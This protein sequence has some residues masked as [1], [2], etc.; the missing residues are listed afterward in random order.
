ME[1]IRPLMPFVALFVITTV[2]MLR[3]RNDICS[4]EPRMLFVLFGTIFSNIC[5]STTSSSCNYRMIINF[6]RFQ[7][8]LIV[9]QMSDTRTECW[10]FF[11][12][13]LLLVVF[14][15]ILPSP[16]FLYIS[17][18]GERWL[19]Y[20]LT[21]SATIAH[22]HYGQGVVSSMLLIGICVFTSGTVQ[23]QLCK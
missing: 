1:A 13:P 10:N 8:R 22:I 19:V 17:A 4:L 15:S 23:L 21:A 16:W 5:V 11:F 14:V 3:S 20:T 9:A 12:W 6:F 2:W 18:T 7:C